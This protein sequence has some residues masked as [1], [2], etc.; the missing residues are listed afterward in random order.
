M[1][2]VNNVSHQFYSSS[3]NSLFRKKQTGVRALNDVSLQF[4]DGEVTGLLGVNGAGKSTLMRV[5]SGLIEPVNG[6]VT[7]DGL[8]VVSQGNSARAKLGMLPDNSGLYPRLSARENIQ[9]FGELQGVARQELAERIET[10]VTTLDMKDIIDRPAQGFSLGERMKT[11]LCRTLI[12]NPN[13]ILLDEPTNGL[14]VF[15]TRAVRHLLARMRDEQRCVVLSSHL[16]YEI[17]NLCDRIVIIHRGNI[18]ADGSQQEVCDLA[19][20]HSL[21]DAFVTLIERAQ[22][23]EVLT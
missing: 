23:V 4:N 15:T 13:N 1:I 5:I 6:S 10:F 18:I 9:Y 17:E 16:M 19:G 12:H 2:E 11:A 20:E 21:E 22:I 3:N 7:I 14:D 8:S